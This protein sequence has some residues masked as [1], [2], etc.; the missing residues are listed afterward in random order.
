MNCSQAKRI[1]IVDF[2][3]R[4]GLRPAKIKGRFYW[5][6]SPYRTERSASFRV[7]SGTNLWK[8]WGDDQKGDIINLVMLMF[9][10]DQSG[11]LAIL[12][13]G[14]IGPSVRPTNSSSLVAKSPDIRILRTAKVSSYPL[15][16][17]ITKDRGIPQG[18]V[19]TYVQECFYTTP[20]REQQNKAPFFALG[21]RNDKGGYELRSPKFKGSTNPKAISTVWGTEPN[22]VTVFEGFMS[23]LSAMAFFERK[24]PVHT[25]I[26]LNSL[27]LLNEET[28]ERLSYYERVNL[29]LDNDDAGRK[30]TQ[31]VLASI[32]RAVDYS[33]KYYA[34]HK[35]FNDYLIQ[36]RHERQQQYTEK[37]G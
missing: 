37:T 10:V 12:D 20:D 3:S 11:A 35:D 14:S 19:D 8:D 27:S 29:F 18:I 17:Y 28:L 34:Q 2:L 13:R 9:R 22:T 26:V 33:P 16:Q 31:K 32:P 30:A 23:F 15:V 5:Y 4:Q 1:P 25:A 24:K 6:R 36:G 7:D 21:F